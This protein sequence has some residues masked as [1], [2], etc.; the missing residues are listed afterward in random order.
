MY[1]GAGRRTRDRI[2]EAVGGSID[3]LSL[4]RPRPGR[5]NPEG[6]KI[7]NPAQ[8]KPYMTLTLELSE[9]LG[10]ELASEAERLGLPLAE[11][12]IR[13]LAVGRTTSAAPRSGAELIAYWQS[14]GLIGSR[15]DWG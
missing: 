1:L 7:W 3:G 6:V 11:Y 14:E 13:V 5:Y 9:E 12:A 10:T 4:L 2:A 15:P 8:G